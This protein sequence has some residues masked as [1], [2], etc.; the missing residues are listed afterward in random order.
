MD[1]TIIKERVLAITRLILTVLAVV[2][3]FLVAQGIN[4][5]PLAEDSVMVWVTHGVDAFIAVYCGWWKNNNVTKKAIAKS[6]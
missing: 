1:S 6:A 5:I 3:S 4:P 2:N